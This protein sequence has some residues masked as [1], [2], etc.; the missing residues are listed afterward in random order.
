MAVR[1][2]PYQ[3]AE[4]IDHFFFLRLFVVCDLFCRSAS[5]LYAHK[6]FLCGNPR[7]EREPVI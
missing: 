4:E 1:G 6:I 5:A 3:P 2:Q 7:P